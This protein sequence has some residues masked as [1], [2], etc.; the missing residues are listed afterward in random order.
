MKAI[1]VAWFF[2]IMPSANAVCQATRCGREIT[3]PAV[4]FA[5]DLR[6]ASGSRSAISVSRNVGDNHE[7]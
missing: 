4:G 1:A 5:P 7:D 3:L 2:S 6:L